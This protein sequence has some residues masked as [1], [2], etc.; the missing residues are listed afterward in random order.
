MKRL[1]FTTF[2]FCFLLVLSQYK[3][4]NHDKTIIN[5]DTLLYKST[6]EIV[7]TNHSF[8]E[9]EMIEKTLNNYIQ[10]SSYN[11]LEKLESAFAADASLYLTVK[12]TFKRLTPVDYLNYFKNKKKGVYN[13]RTGNILSIEIYRDIATAKVEIFIPERKTKLMDLFLLKKLKGDWKIITK[14]ATKL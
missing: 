6:N 9:K 2:P 4:M 1:F 14:T 8:S 10:G 12:G 3:M 13:G 7:K 5:N 11:E